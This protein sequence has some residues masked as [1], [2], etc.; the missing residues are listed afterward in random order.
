MLQPIETMTIEEF[1]ELTDTDQPE[2]LD[3]LP[4]EVVVDRY[5]HVTLILGNLHVQTFDTMADL[6]LTAEGLAKD[7]IKLTRMDQ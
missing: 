3:A 7:G 2:L 5:G 6:E 4:D 1:E